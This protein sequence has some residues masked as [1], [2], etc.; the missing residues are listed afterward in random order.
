MAHEQLLADVKKARFRRR[1]KL[2]M[3]LLFAGG[4]I[5][6]IVMELLP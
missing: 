6:R 2:L 5:V 1:A 4:V 3:S